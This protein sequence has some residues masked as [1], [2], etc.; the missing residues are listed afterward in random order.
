MSSLRYGLIAF[1]FALPAPVRGSDLC[2]ACNSPDKTYLC[3]VKKADKI[4]S[5][6]GDKALNKICSQVLRRK[7][8]H[9]SCTVISQAPCTGEKTTIGWSEVKQI[10][11]GGLDDAESKVEKPAAKTRDAGPVKSSNDALPAPAANVAP[12]SQKSSGPPAVA[13]PVTQEQTNEASAIK[14]PKPNDS[15]AITDKDRPSLNDSFKGAGSN[16][17]DAAKKTWDCVSSMF[18]KC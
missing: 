9:A 17:K 14:N 5:F 3:S 15:A 11:A 7:G 4:Q 12:S 8:P 10:I 13:E 6:A 1:A 2:V 16:F 18:G